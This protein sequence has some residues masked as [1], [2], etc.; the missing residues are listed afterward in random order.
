MVLRAIDINCDLGEGMGNDAQ[1]MPYLD[2]CNIACGGHYGDVQSMSETLL[3][4]K[5]HGVKVGAHPSYP[6]K[7]NFGRQVLSLQPETLQQSLFQQIS[8]FKQLCQKYEIEMH[9]IKLHGALY[10]QVVGDAELASMVLNVFAAIAPEIKI[11]VPHQSVIAL[12]AEDYFQVV[13]EAFIDRCYH[14][15]LT[16]VSRS[17]DNAV[18][19]DSNIAWQQLEQMLKHGTVPS[20]EGQNTT[21]KADTFCVHGDE[22]NAINLL[23]HIRQCLSN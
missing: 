10:N 9:H 15:D 13:Y 22:D 23:K 16:L 18:I 7:E 4:A 1:L 5:K 6:D 12:L 2:S 11:Y 3:L 21:I 14:S 8:N 17:Q 19:K 20:I